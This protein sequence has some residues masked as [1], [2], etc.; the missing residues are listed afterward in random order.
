MEDLQAVGNNLFVDH[1]DFF[2]VNGVKLVRQLGEFKKITFQ[3]YLMSESIQVD[4]PKF[5]LR[6][7]R[8][9][10]P[11]TR[12]ALGTTQPPVNE[13]CVFPRV[14]VAGALC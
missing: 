2:Y 14:K 9:F 8:G 10:P 6:K 1:L 12:A 4:G 3:Y 7:G 5:D 13:Y 11:P